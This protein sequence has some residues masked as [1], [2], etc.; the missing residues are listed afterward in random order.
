MFNAFTTQYLK[1]SKSFYLF[2]T[3]RL[4]SA[5]I[6]F[7]FLI[8]VFFPLMLPFVLYGMI[9]TVN[10]TSVQTA[11]IISAIPFMC[12]TFVLL[13]KDFFNGRSVAKRVFGYQ[14]IQINTRNTAHPF[15]CMLGNITL[16][17]WPLEVF[18]SLINPSRRLGDFLAGTA[19]IESSIEE[20]KS[21]LIEIENAKWNSSHKRLIWAA[22][23][24]SGLFS[25]L[26]VVLQYLF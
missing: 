3:R 18:V 20:P 9:T 22:V 23:A 26:G 25:A 10:V 19:V 1:R 5:G 7:M 17:I 6:D 21:I 4:K 11:S 2:P 8:A 13:N 12:F 14:V 16:I 24:F 15:Q